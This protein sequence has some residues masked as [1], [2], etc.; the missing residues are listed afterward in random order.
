M[1]PLKK[2]SWFLSLKVVTQEEKM[3][4]SLRAQWLTPRESE[5]S[6]DRCTSAS[7][8]EE[9]QL[10]RMALVGFFIGSKPVF[11]YVRNTLEKMTHAEGVDIEMV[12]I[13]IVDAME[14]IALTAVQSSSSSANSSGTTSGSSSS[15]MGGSVEPE[16]EGGSPEELEADEM[17]D[18]DMPTHVLSKGP[19]EVP[20]S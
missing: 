9:A 14:Q 19:P 13:E 12:D 3:E 5:E 4:Q 17:P 11:T 16:S 20:R 1:G 8:E 7:V 18:V 10:L 15:S 6:F 2:V